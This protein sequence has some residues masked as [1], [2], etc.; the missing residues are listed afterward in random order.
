MDYA[1]IL[2]VAI[3][4]AA[5]LLA[6]L[7]GNM[8]SLKGGLDGF[9]LITVLGLITITL[10]PE[11]LSQGGLLGLLIA[12]FG[13]V[14]PWVAERLFHKSEEMTHRVLMFVSAIAL[15][16]HAAS[17]GAILAFANQS[18]QGNFI[19]AGVVLHRIGVA[20]AVWWLLRPILT[21][22]GGISVMAALGIMTIVG[23]LIVIFAGEWYN[24]PLI[25]YWQAFAAGSLFH[26]VMHPLDDNHNAAPVA[27]TLLAH[28]IGTAFG[29]LFIMSLIASH[30]LQHVPLELSTVQQHHGEHHDVDMMASIGKL[31]APIMLLLIGGIGAYV[32]IHTG[33]MSRAYKALQHITPWTLM[34]WLLGGLAAEIMP[35]LLPEPQSG[36]ILLFIWLAIIAVIMVHTGA[37]AF[38]SVLMPALHSHSHHHSHSGH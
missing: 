10:L 27:R 23:Y 34:I 31:L 6:Q 13:F 32:R 16:V 15:I 33:T 35:S 30:Y 29:I 14:L 18:D 12:G 3:L 28:R 37:R 21:T 24:V 17:D 7:V 4:L 5:P 11:A 36:E 1:L 26:I 9:V 38:F 2:S 8:P 22:I 20:V 19:A 25:G